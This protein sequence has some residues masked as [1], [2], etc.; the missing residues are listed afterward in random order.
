MTITI[1]NKE[2]TI[3]T[4]ARPKYRSDRNDAD[5]WVAMD[6]ADE[7]DIDEYGDPHQY[8]AWYYVPEAWYYTPEMDDEG[9]ELDQ[10]DYDEP[11]DLQDIG[12]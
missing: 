6:I 2:Y 4:D 8:I 5:H 3:I 1:N 11:H 7:S 12:Y 10:I 9:F